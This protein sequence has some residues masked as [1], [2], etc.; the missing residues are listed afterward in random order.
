MTDSRIRREIESLRNE[1]NRHNYLYYVASQPVISDAEYDRL[2]RRLV[3]LEKAYPDLKCADSPTQR[4]GAPLPAFG[5]AITHGEPMMSLENAFTESEVQSFD[6]RVRKLAGVD[7]IEYLVEPKYDGVSASLIYEQGLFLL[8]ATRGD[9]VR[10]EDITANIRTIPTVPLRLGVPGEEVEENKP[11]PSRIEIRGEVLISKED[12]REINRIQASEGL[13][14]FA[15][16]RNAASGALRQLDPA[17][18]SKRRLSFYGWGVGKVEGMPFRSQSETLQQL[19]RWGFRISREISKCQSIEEAIDRHHRMEKDRRE[20]DFEIDGAVIKVN[21]TDYQEKLGATA[22]HPRWGL[23]YKFKPLQMTTRILRID[24]QT[25]RTGILTPVAILEPVDIGGVTVSRATLHTEGE[26]AE[27]ELLIGDTVFIERAGDVIPEVIKPV[28]EKRTGRERAFVMP[29]NCP[30]CGSSV[31]KKGAYLYCINLL[32]PAQAQG[33]IV[34]LCSRKGF[35]IQGLGKKKADQLLAAGLLKEASDVFYLEKKRL[36]ALPGWNE[37]SSQNLIDQIEKAKKVPFARLIYALSI[38]DVGSTGSRTLAAHFRSLEE[39]QKSSL[40]DLTRIRGI[41]PEIGSSIVRFFGEERN[42]KAIA[43]ILASGIQIE[44]PPA[45]SKGGWEGKRI[46]ITGTFR[47][48][49][50]EQ[51]SQWIEE[52]GG[53]VSSSVSP[54]TDYLFAGEDP[55]SKLGRAEKLEIPLL[56]EEEILARMNKK[57]DPVRKVR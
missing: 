11:L 4:I 46:V 26:L 52:N 24:V 49:T 7:Q 15:N 18:A 48:F 25:G 39:L 42:R 40:E 19:K 29:D 21:R 34:H 53:T 23:A 32:C 22:R 51:L 56:K 57:S 43:R 14:L 50:R 47:S 36:A 31:E 54:K 38:L 20:I 6:L 13:P 37:K 5:K 45:R 55:G 35:D 28:T 16:P 8:G 3:D 33:K 2:Y 41:G 30:A 17:V 9:G 1:I 44:Y 10:G 12:F 27:K